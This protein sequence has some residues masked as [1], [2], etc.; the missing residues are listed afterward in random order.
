MSDNKNG[1]D[2]W[3]VVFGASEKSIEEFCESLAARY[4]NLI[5]VDRDRS[6]LQKKANDLYKKYG[7]RVEAVS[8]SPDNNNPEDIIMD[9]IREMDVS[10]LVPHGCSDSMDE[11]I[12]D[13]LQKNNIVM[14]AHKSKKLNIY[15]TRHFA[16]TAN[17]F[18]EML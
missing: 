12:R 17:D 10:L 13:N 3:A 16:E 11:S 15:A 9:R 2:V 7:V 6:K 1:Q 18:I 5:L 8:I 4:I 14:E